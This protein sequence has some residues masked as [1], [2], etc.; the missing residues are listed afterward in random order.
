MT[1]ILGKT[2]QQSIGCIAPF[3]GVAPQMMRFVDHYEV[4]GTLLGECA[5][6]LILRQQLQ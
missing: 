3:F 4:P 2:L 6:L 5:E 1:R